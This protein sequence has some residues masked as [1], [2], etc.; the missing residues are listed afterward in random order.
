MIHIK[1]CQRNKLHPKIRNMTFNLRTGNTGSQDIYWTDPI[2]LRFHANTSASVHHMN[3]SSIISFTFSRLCAERESMDKWD[4]GS[5]FFSFVFCATSFL[6]F[7]SLAES[8]GTKS[9]TGWMIF[10][11]MQRTRLADDN[12]GIDDDRSMANERNS[13]FKILKSEVSVNIQHSWYPLLID[14][15]LWI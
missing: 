11:S 3:F 4:D 9:D 8:S 6:H 15:H 12:R 10:F 2:R 13:R 7:S 5:S 1:Y 14:L